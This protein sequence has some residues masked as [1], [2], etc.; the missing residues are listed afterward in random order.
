MVVPFLL[1][2]IRQLR[3]LS[4]YKSVELKN[5]LTIWLNTGKWSEPDQINYDDLSDLLLQKI[6][7]DNK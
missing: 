6:S 7:S 4:K 1:S 3:N 5:A 2:Y